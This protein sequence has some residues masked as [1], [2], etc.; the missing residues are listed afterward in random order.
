MKSDHPFISVI[1]PHLNQADSLDACLSSLDAQ[2][3]DRALFEIIVVD[4]GSACPPAE[5]VA[6][7]PGVRMM[8]QLRPGPGPARN[9]GA[10]NAKADILAFID[11]DCRAH[12]EWLS[13]ALQTIHSCP[14]RTVLG[15]DVRIWRGDRRGFTAIEAY[16]LVFSYRFKLYIEQH[17][18]CGTGNLVTRRNA[19]ETIGPFAGI[20][21]AEDMEWG[22]RARQ[23]GFRFQY[24]PKLIVFHPARR[25]LRELYEQWDR[26]TQHFRNMADNAP[27]WRVRWTLRALAILISPFRDFAKVLASDRIK[28]CRRVWVPSWF[29][30]ESALIARGPCS[31]CWVRGAR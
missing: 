13:I 27:A 14:E 12:P 23:A 30:S 19:F 7:H 5:T 3:L 28:D 26:H 8:R 4:N 31:I 16:E 10:Q 21:C 18:Y 17:G 1:I 29:F 22:Q 20:E 2:S 11:A 24:V 9:T 15:G 6:R 25:S